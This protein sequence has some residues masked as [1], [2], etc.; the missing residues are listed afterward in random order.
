VP[1]GKIIGAAI[2]ATLLDRFF[3]AGN[4]ASRT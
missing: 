1:D 3:I 4:R 2:G